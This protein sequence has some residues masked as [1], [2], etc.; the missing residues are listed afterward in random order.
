MSIYAPE[1]DAFDDEE[2]HLLREMANDLAFGINAIRGRLQRERA[3]AALRHSRDLMQKA[4][5]IGQLGSWE[6]DLATNE[7]AWSDEMYHLLGLS[8]GEPEEPTFETLLS[9]VVPEEKEFVQMEISKAC[10]S[11]QPFDFTFG[12]VTC[13]GRERILHAS[14]EVVR[15]ELGS[16]VKVIGIDQDITD[17]KLAVEKLNTVL[18][19]T[20]GALAKTTA[21]RD[22]YTATHQEH[23]AELAVAVAHEMGLSRS[24]IEGIRIAGLIH[25]I[26]KISVPAEILTKTGALSEPEFSIIKEHP[27][28]AYGILKE[29]DFPWPIAEAIL[30]HHER[31]NGSGYP[32]GVKGET[33][34]VE[35]RIIAVADVVEAMTNHRP[36]RPALGIDAALHEITDRKHDLYDPAVVDACVT[37]FKEKGFA[38]SK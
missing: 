32:N 2:A 20:I 23:V 33:I 17:R 11:G 1:P 3:E 25:D 36:Y 4:E 5:A 21:S 34:C 12:V 30:Q 9:F 7:V 10:E 19:A 14:G 8:P 6:W 31:W 37:L 26:G 35:A 28:V 18:Q 29:I 27:K 16:P 22:A 24:S 13:D 38:F 15:N